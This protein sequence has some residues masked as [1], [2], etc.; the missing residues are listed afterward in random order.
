MHVN[1]P[2]CL[3]GGLS[4]FTKIHQFASKSKSYCMLFLCLQRCEINLIRASF[5]LR[6]LYSPLPHHC[7]ISASYGLPQG[8]NRCSY[9]DD[10]YQPWS[11]YQGGMQDDKG[12]LGSEK[13]N[14][15]DTAV[16]TLMKY[17]N[18]GIRKECNH[19][20]ETDGLRTKVSEIGYISRTRKTVGLDIMSYTYDY[21]FYMFHPN[22]LPIF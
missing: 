12:M 14:R 17:R 18:Y 11:V 10:I 16:E 21:T 20:D 15:L 2:A 22:V 6:H 3:C 5:F 7:C 13:Y 9:I 19:E 4:D 8:T 1:N